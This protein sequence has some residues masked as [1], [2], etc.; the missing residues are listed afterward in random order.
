VPE[1]RLI[2]ENGDNVGVVP[3]ERGVEMAE[4]AAPQEGPQYSD[5]AKAAMERA[6]TAREAVEV[7]GGLMDE[8]GYSTY[9]GN[10]HLFADED[11][12]WV[13]INF[14]HP[15]G[16]L[17]AA[18]R[19]SSDE[20]RVSYFGYILD[21]P[22][23]HEDDPDF[24]ASDELVSFAE[25]QGWWE[26]EGDTRVVGERYT[27]EGAT[28]TANEPIVSLVDL[29]RLRAVIQVTERDYDG[30]V[31]DLT[32]DEDA[33]NFAVQGGVIV[34]NSTRHNTIDKLYDRGYVEENPPK[35]TELAKGVVEAAEEYAD[36]V[37]SEGMTAELEA[38][39]TAIAEGEATLQD[40]TE[41]SREMLARVF[42]EL[43]G[44]EEEIG[45]HIREAMKRDKL[46][47]P[48]PDCGEQLLVRKSRYGSHFVGCDGYPDCEYT[49]P[50]PKKGSPLVI[51]ETC[52]EHGL[53]HV[54]MLAGRGTFVHGCPQCKAD[55]AD[56]EEDRIIG[57][58]PECGETHDGE[59]AIKR[60][61]SGSRL[62]GC[63]RYPDCDYSLPL[64]RRGDIEVTDEVCEE[65]D[66]PELVVHSGDDPWE[67]G[68]PICNFREFQ[69]ERSGGQKDGLEAISGIG[70]KTAEKLADAGVD[71]VDALKDV[72]SDEL[73]GS[74]QGISADQIEGWKAK[75]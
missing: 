59:L 34:H 11:E 7:V 2:D 39:M 41:E 49:L 51:D 20:I 18:E 58:C 45:T 70:K 73:A 12:G 22:V 17:W 13:F 38:D 6:S 10:S 15:D 54:K 36:M 44:A 24:M 50:L 27:Q 30:A 8:H 60:V 35:P 68:C 28:L 74:L 29:R 69:A 67:L 43:E 71:S 14:A 19:L 23:D 64:P 66:L 32:I 65:H 47:G 52:E 31:Y 53:K 5:L 37:V 4:E 40:V 56:E 46:L 63:T 1:I 55:E 62:V 16:D 75:A 72:D 21:F 57:E 33:P 48:C 61:R 42:E 25:E 3:P 26:G 9:G